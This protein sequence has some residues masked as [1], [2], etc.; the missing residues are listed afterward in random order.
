[1]CDTTTW[2]KIGWYCALLTSLMIMVMAVLIAYGAPFPHGN[3]LLSGFCVWGKP[4]T[5]PCKTHEN[6]HAAATL[7]NIVGLIVFIVMYVV[8]KW[9]GQNPSIG[10]YV[11]CVFLQI[12]HAFAHYEGVVLDC[13]ISISNRMT[14]ILVAIIIVASIA[15][16]GIA[17][18]D[19]KQVLMISVITIIPFVYVALEDSNLFIPMGFNYF[20]MSSAC[21]TII[22]GTALDTNVGWFLCLACVMELMEMSM[23]DYFYQKIGGH[24]W[25]D[26]GILAFAIAGAQIAE[27]ARVKECGIESRDLIQ[28]I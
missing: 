2:N 19:M 15:M 3:A 4:Y 21:Q 8:K 27:G 12:I 7:V 13:V 6:S 20:F 17:G 14:M 9:S 18:Y 22:S 1:M 11:S 25:T 28:A 23:C 16:Y 26:V 24:M 10:I 5:I